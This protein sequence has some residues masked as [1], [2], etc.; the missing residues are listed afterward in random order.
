MRG[1]SH[2]LSALIVFAALCVATLAAAQPTEAARLFEEGRELA[3]QQKWADACDRF[4]KSLALDPAPGTKLNL[5][6]CLEK[7]GQVR[8]G[9]LMFEEAARDFDRTNDARAKFA[10][11]RANAAQGKLATLVI[12]VADSSRAGLAIKIGER[13]AIPQPEIVERVDPGPLAVTVTAPERDTFKTWVTTSAGKT[14]VVDV[15]VL[16]EPRPATAEQPVAPPVVTPDVPERRRRS[17]VVLSL[18]LG[19]AGALALIASGAIGL[20]ARSQ[21]N[22]A[23]EGAMPQCVD[24]PDGPVCS[25]DGKSRI[26]DAGT[27][28][29]IATAFAIGGAVLAGAAVV[30]YVTAPKERSIA[31]TPTATASSVGVTIGGSF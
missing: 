13:A 24:T 18:A 10:H 2:V 16:A 21:Y 3:K 1:R 4:Q 22:D 31:V 25:A 5:G 9:W 27:K 26:D 12:K 8:K 23:F 19:G 20:S 14:T 28:A 30:L 17:R 11:D 7:Q 6:D 29:D 15:P